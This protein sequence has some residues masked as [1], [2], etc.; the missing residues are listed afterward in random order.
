M[1]G[2]FQKVYPSGIGMKNEESG[3]E[4][5]KADTLYVQMFG[6]FQMRYGGKPLN[7]ERIR[8]THFTSLMQLLLHNVS[9]GVSRDY[10][11][12]SLLGER[13]IENRHQAL[14]T[15]IY[16]AKRKLKNM[17]LPEENYIALKKGIYYWT[18]QIPVYEDA[19]AFDELFDK[20]ENTE[21]E[22]ERLD[23]L[24]EACYLYKG[25]FL[26]TYTS[27]I[28]ASAEA[29]RYRVLFGE[30]VKNTAD[31]LRKRKDWLRLE[32]LGRYVNKIAP[33]ADWECLIMEALVESGK[34]EEAK[35]L[36]AD[37]AD[38]YL[39]ELGVQPSAK[40]MKMF[41]KL[42]SQIKHSYEVLDQIQD[43][44]VEDP[45]IIQGG[46]EC[47]YPVFQGIY[48]II[49][50]MMERGGQSVYLMLC[51]L[52]DSK[53]KPMKEGERLEEMSERLRE[54][55]RHSVRHGDIIN[56]YG[57]G[58]FLVLLVNT[59]RENCEIVEKRINR[60]F[61][62]GRQRTGVQYHVNSVICE[63]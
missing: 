50:R 21:D 41:Q 5:E 46:Y 63:A 24:L 20:A 6:N 26:S 49:N 58:Q 53:G 62:V 19:A 45:S 1:E 44:L 14:Q 48:Q 10:L 34:Y 23:I 36:Y 61:L 28:W 31:I 12:D 43:N 11:E 7:G 29:R 13:D 47:S 42:G 56:Q 2:H 40:L 32:K 15:I 54:S 25:E 55:I 27:V 18:P 35:K 9:A 3:M 30:C 4:V 52:V 60:N 37:T 17:G 22:D 59:T 57:R 38:I 16:K 51:T 8:D 39:K 33:F